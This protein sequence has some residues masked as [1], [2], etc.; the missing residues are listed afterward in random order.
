MRLVFVMRRL[1]FVIREWS[2]VMPYLIFGNCFALDVMCYLLFDMC[3]L[4]VL[5]KV[6]VYCALSV[7]CCV[8]FAPYC[9]SFVMHYVLPTINQPLFIL[10][11]QSSV[12]TNPHSPVDIHSSS[13]I[14]HCSVLMVQDSGFSTQHSV[15]S[16]RHSCFVIRWSSFVIRYSFVSRQ[17]SFIVRH[18]TVVSRRLLFVIIQYP[19]PM[20][21][22]ALLIF[23]SPVIRYSLF[24]VHDYVF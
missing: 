5:S 23:F 8:F 20:I 3:Y 24:I 21:H 13:S 16:I 19:W 15:L 12:F 1:I 17:S 4:H 6:V 18:W 14:T 7:V 10:I 22:H 9:L 2:C 11:T